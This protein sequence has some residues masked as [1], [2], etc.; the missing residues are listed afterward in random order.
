MSSSEDLLQRRKDAKGTSL[1]TRQRFAPLREKTSS[2]SLELTFVH[3]RSNNN[4]F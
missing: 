1:E 4:E 2:Y 3:S